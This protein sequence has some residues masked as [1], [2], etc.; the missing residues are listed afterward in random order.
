MRVKTDLHAGQ[1]YYNFTFEDCD[2]IRNYWKDQAQKMQ[3]FAD[4]GVMS[5]G[6]YFPPAVYS[7]EPKP[8]GAQPPATPTPPATGDTLSCGWVGGIHYPDMSGVCG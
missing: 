5:P 8:G 4:K 1:E 3:L 7:Y 2:K 6:L